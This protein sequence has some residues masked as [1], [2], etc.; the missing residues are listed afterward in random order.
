MP[1]S[2]LRS[3]SLE[4]R[5]STLDAWQ[6]WGVRIVLGMVITA[7]IRLVLIS[8]SGAAVSPQPVLSR[9]IQDPHHPADFIGIS[10]G[11]TAGQHQPASPSRAGTEPGVSADSSTQRAAVLGSAD[12]LGPQEIRTSCESAKAAG[13]WLL[14][15]EVARPTGGSSARAQA[16]MSQGG[17]RAA[18]S[19]A[20][21]R[22]LDSGAVAH[23]AV[24]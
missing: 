7:V 20:W 18:D 14:S 19:T 8:T 16:P 9:A 15:S 2:A 12:G 21:A 6:T 11:Q 1:A 13:S 22:A 10:A 17:R 24:G 4:D 23:P 5:I 3:S